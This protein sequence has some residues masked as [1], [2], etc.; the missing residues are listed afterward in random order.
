MY[1][2][3]QVAADLNISPAQLRKLTERFSRLLSDEAHP[4][5]EN[6]RRATRVYTDADVATLQVIVELQAQGISDAELED[7]L[8]S[9]LGNS[10]APITVLTSGPNQEFLPPQAAVAAI[11]QALQQ[12]GDT[13]QALLNSQQGQQTLLNVVVTDAIALKDE[14]ERLRKRIRTMEEEITRLKESE[15]NYRLSL[16]E[17]INK[18][19]R[20]GE[21][22]KSWWARLFRSE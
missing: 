21:G 4:A 13:Q 19:E 16:E 7:R 14:N 2:P 3:G 18:I 15:M 8:N 11:G 9:A 12:I 1:R 10:P 20:E 5:L 22:R 6:G 17:R